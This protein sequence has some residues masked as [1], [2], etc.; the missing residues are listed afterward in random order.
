M[1]DRVLVIQ[2]DPQSGPGVLEQALYERGVQLDYRFPYRDTGDVDLEA[3]GAILSFG[4]RATPRFEAP[5]LERERAL[6]RRIV[7]AGIPYLGV[8]LG[9][10]LLAQAAGGAAPS[11]PPTQIGWRELRPTPAAADDPLFHDVARPAF[12]WHYNG[13]RAPGRATVLARSADER[14]AQAFR[15][16]SAAWGV[17]FHLE[18]DLDMA[19][20]FIVRFPGMVRE[21]SVDPN[22]LR[23]RTAELAPGNVAWARDVVARLV[24]TRVA[25]LGR[26]AHAPWPS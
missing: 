26:R 23:R 17:Q 25:G 11:D 10:E 20:A 6:V 12:E 5:W 7:A 14:L 24:S 19:A 9:G 3:Y 2:N 13:I 8:C 15:V 21:A 1:G 4:G 16:G 22:G 18:I